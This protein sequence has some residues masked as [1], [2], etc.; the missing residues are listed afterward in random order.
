MRGL[1]IEDLLAIPDFL[2]YGEANLYQENLDAFLTIA[3]ELDLKG[4]YGG[5]GGNEKGKI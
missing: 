4:L 3:E 1:K 5:G 2:Y